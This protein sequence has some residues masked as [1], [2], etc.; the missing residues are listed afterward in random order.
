M[1]RLRKIL[2]VAALALVGLSSASMF[3][4]AHAGNPGWYTGSS[5]TWYHNGPDGYY[6]GRWSH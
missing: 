1:I 3:G 5:G 6:D 2:A 4:A